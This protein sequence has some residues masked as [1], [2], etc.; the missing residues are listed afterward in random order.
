V[1]QDTNHAETMGLTPRGPEKTIEEMLV[2]SGDSQSDLATSDDG[3]DEEGN[4]DDTAQ[5]KLSDD[6]EPGWVMGTITNTVQQ[7]MER[8]QQK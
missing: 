4:A 2:A 5:G 6:D 3:E 8:C 1:Q 7:R